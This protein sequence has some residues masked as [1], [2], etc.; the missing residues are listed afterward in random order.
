MSGLASKKMQAQRLAA[1]RAALREDA[2]AGNEFEDTDFL[3]RMTSGAT[4][5]SDPFPETP[6]SEQ[7]EQELAALPQEDTRP[8]IMSQERLLRELGATGMV[9]PERAHA[10]KKQFI[11]DVTPVGS[12]KLLKEG[13]EERDILKG[14]AGGFMTGLDA[15]GVGAALKASAPLIWRSRLR[16]MVEKLPDEVH[17]RAE[18]FVAAT[19]D[20]TRT[21]RGGPDKGKTYTKKGKAEH[22]VPGETWKEAVYS[23]LGLKRNPKAGDPVLVKGEQQIDRFGDPVTHSEFIPDPDF[24]DGPPV[25]LTEIQAHTLDKYLDDLDTVFDEAQRQN[26]SFKHDLDID[27]GLSRD[28]ILKFLDENPVDIHRHHKLPGRTDPGYV[29]EELAEYEKLRYKVADARRPITGL[30]E[31]GGYPLTADETH[32]LSM[33]PRYFEYPSGEA[34]KRSLKQFYN[35]IP[36]NWVDHSSSGSR[37]RFRGGLQ[38]ATGADASWMRQPSALDHLRMASKRLGVG[39]TGVFPNTYVTGEEGADLQRAFSRLEFNDEAQMDNLLGALRSVNPYLPLERR[40]NELSFPLELIGE[41]VYLPREAVEI[42]AD[43]NSEMGKFEQWLSREEMVPHMRQKLVS[44]PVYGTPLEAVIELRRFDPD[45]L[46]TFLN[47]VSKAERA[48]LGH[49]EKKLTTALEAEKRVVA[50][51]DDLYSNPEWKKLIEAS[52]NFEAFTKNTPPAKG[53]P[54]S[55]GA[56]R[57]TAEKGTNYQEHIV[58]I[59]APITGQHKFKEGHHRYIPEGSTRMDTYPGEQIHW[60]SKDREIDAPDGGKYKMLHV[61]EIQADQA[62]QG[63]M[64]GFSEEENAKLKEVWGRKNLDWTADRDELILM[65][66]FEENPEFIQDPESGYS[67]WNTDALVGA[68]QYDR[69]R[70]DPALKARIDKLIEEGESLRN[71]RSALDMGPVPPAA[72]QDSQATTR[73]AL[74]DILNYAKDNDYDGVSFTNAAQAEERIR[75][76]KNAAQFQYGVPGDPRKKG[77][78]FK[79]IRELTGVAMDTVEYPETLLPA[80]AQSSTFNAVLLKDLIARDYKFA[81]PLAAGAGGAAGLKSLK[82]DTKEENTE[83]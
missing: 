4:G 50:I 2:V 72:Y 13:V 31:V 25:K 21:I 42:L 54:I 74:Q 17:P 35:A 71:T 14:A 75:M 59:D 9:S 33:D 27:P 58:E 44:S 43:L 68:L 24:K 41:G 60:R 64:R 52:D 45:R 29:G 22:T 19:P 11:E 49:L 57:A 61:E 30:R 56:V 37:T 7:I 12:V 51:Q 28:E 18:Q 36:L 5:G 83:L 53:R 63:R 70:N 80:L 69:V 47:E 16:E 39:E 46:D 15:T 3:S 67:R 76:P 38:D 78:P 10:A 34:Y 40:A 62:Q 73:L 23:K 20:T 65:N 8:S 81:L 6:I 1:S 26:W 79:G 48:H 77:R 32:R 66:R 55:A 82:G